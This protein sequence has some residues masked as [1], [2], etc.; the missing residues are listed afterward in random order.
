MTSIAPAECNDQCTAASGVVAAHWP[1]STARW[2]SLA[3][4]AGYMHQTEPAVW[5]AD[6]IR[7]CPADVRCLTSM[8]SD[9]K[10]IGQ[11]GRVMGD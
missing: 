2:P 11:Q 7:M 3:A 9:D 5:R 6:A 10:G 8:P 1:M 4:Q